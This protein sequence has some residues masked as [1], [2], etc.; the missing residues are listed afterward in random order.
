MNVVTDAASVLPL[1]LRAMQGGS[2]AR[3][4]EL[5]SALTRHLHAFVQETKLS[6]EEFERALD[7]IVAVGH[8]TGEKKNEAVLLADILGG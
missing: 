2:D 7:F 6:E 5:M 1:V 3:L 8:A 4:S